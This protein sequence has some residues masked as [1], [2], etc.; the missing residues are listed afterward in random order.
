MASRVLKYC[1]KGNVIH[2]FIKDLPVINKR[3]ICK[4]KRKPQNDRM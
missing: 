1:Q 3:V 2:S 4:I